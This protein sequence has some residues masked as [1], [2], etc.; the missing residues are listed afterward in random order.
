MKI[1]V[2]V[3]TYCRPHDLSRCLESLSKQTRLPDETIVVVR[4]TDHS[5]QRF[6]TNYDNI[7]LPVKIVAADKPGQ[8]YAL[9]LGKMNASGDIISITDDDGAPR[10][11][12]L[13]LIEKYF[14]SDA[15]VGGVGGRDWIHVDDLIFNESQKVVGI[16]KWHG[17][18][19]GGH[20]AGVGL[21][22]EVEILKGANMSFRSAAIKLIHF[23]ERLLGKGAQVHNDLGISLQVKKAGWK[24]IY[25]PEVA[26][27]HFIAPRESHE[28]RVVFNQE[29]HFNAV[30][31]ETLILLEYLPT[32]RRF[33]FLIWT[34]LVG[35][36]VYPG[37]LHYILGVFRRDSIAWNRYKTTLS[38]RSHGIAVY[39]IK[40]LPK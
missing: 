37:F 7:K 22:R 14:N 12:W 5:T 25:D 2:I 39:R 19:I 18:C 36:K 13:E 20:H 3:P 38:G 28:D 8:I 17:K 30:H 9:N 4:T 21:P 32:H 40:R 35:S 31:N 23:D 1:S 29:A 16:V 33:V 10:P 27:D 26:I 15:A 6:L 24:L 34:I 11:E